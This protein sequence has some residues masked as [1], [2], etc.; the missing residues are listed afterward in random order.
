MGSKNSKKDY[1]FVIEGLDGA[2]KSSIFY[3]LKSQYQKDDSPPFLN[4]QLIC[5]DYKGVNLY[6]YI[7]VRVKIK[8]N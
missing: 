2:G 6:I 4:L 7:N 1:S 5:L 8:I 3:Y